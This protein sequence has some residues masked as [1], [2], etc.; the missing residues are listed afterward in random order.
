M[1]F[2]FPPKLVFP[3]AAA[4]A[5]LYERSVNRRIIPPRTIAFSSP[6]HGAC[7]VRLEIR[8][9]SL[10]EIHYKRVPVSN[11]LIKRRAI[12][13]RR[14]NTKRPYENV[15]SCVYIQKEK[16]IIFSSCSA[17]FSGL[18]SKTKC[19][20]KQPLPFFYFLSFFFHR[21]RGPAAHIIA[22]V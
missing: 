15:V 12:I 8:Y 1:P 18:C 2:F 4:A 9:F 5:S 14:A 16:K 13:H 17:E 11:G 6:V 19:H 21:F 20:N 22:R 7:V 10:A 3:P